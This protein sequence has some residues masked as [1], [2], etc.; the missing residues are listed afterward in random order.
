[1][2]D[3]FDCLVM[4]TSEYARGFDCTVQSITGRINTQMWKSDSHYVDGDQVHVPATTDRPGF[5]ATKSPGPSANSGTWLLVL[6][7]N[8]AKVMTY[9]R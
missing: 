2:L 8:D 6:D 5:V 3:F 1:M 7:T 9:G 4:T